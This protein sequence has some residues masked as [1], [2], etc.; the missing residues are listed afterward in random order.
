MD[1]RN[2]KDEHRESGFT[3]IEVL[4]T[5]VIIGILAAVAMRSVQ[6]SIDGS[7]I[8]ETQAEIDELIVAIAGN[9]D[10]YNNGMRSDFGY[11]GDVGAVPGSID[12]L[13]TNPGGYTTWDGPYVSRRFTQDADGFKKDAWG[14]NYTFS[15]GI[16]LASTGGGSTAMTKSAAAGAAAMATPPVNGPRTPAGGGRPG[17]PGGGG[18][19]PPRLDHHADQRHDHR[20]S[21]ESAGRFLGR[22]DDLTGLS[23]WCRRDHDGIDESN[24]GRLF[25]D[26]QH[27]GRCSRTDRGLSGD[28]RYRGHIRGAAAQDRRDGHNAIARSAICG[29][30]RWGRWNRSH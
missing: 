16:T 24:S 26:Q 9:P 7:R 11:V 13:V 23:R 17:F 10:L 21:G 3:L 28:I 6:S 18:G 14:N 2:H 12:D 4:M 19:A 8:R 27:S 1:A 25:Y 5:V 15:S 20:C 30:G 22:S 29:G